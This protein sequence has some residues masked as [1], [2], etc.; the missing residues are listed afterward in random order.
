MSP[1]EMKMLP[2]GASVVSTHKFRR[3]KF[4]GGQG[5]RRSVEWVSD[6]QVTPIKGIFI[7]YRTLS[8]GT[9]EYE[10]GFPIWFSDSM[11]QAAL[12]VT[13]KSRN[14]ILVPI[15]SLLAYT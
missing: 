4:D 11:F 1:E 8:N 10:E 13:H 12:I 14:P 5:R 3:R 6:L 9:W 7:G 15:P 2:L